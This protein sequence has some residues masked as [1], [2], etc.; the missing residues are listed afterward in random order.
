MLNA[1]CNASVRRDAAINQNSRELFKTLCYNFHGTTKIKCRR[2]VYLFIE[3]NSQ[4][5]TRDPKFNRLRII[6]R[7]NSNHDEKH[8]KLLHCRYAGG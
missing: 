7:K 5:Q 3:N 8:R 1:R 2:S 6:A 4:N